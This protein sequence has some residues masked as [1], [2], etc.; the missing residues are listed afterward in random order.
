MNVVGSLVAPKG[1]RDHPHVVGIPSHIQHELG[2]R[3]QRPYYRLEHRTHVFFGRVL[4]GKRHCRED[5]G[6]HDGQNMGSNCHLPVRS[7]G[8]VSRQVCG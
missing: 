4:S 8:T 2:L 6:R 7:P 1:N 5:Y 3:S